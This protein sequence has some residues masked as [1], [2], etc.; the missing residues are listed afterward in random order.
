MPNNLA[1]LDRYF[2]I[3][4]PKDL[5]GKFEIVDSMNKPVNVSKSNLLQQIISL[6]I[7]TGEN[8]AST[9]LPTMKEIVDQVNLFL[10]QKNE[11]DS[12]SIEQFH[13]LIK[14]YS[15]DRVKQSEKYW[16]GDKKQT[17]SWADV[18]KNSNARPKLGVIQTTTPFA[19]LAVRNTNK[20]SLFMNSIPTLEFTRA[21][22]FLDVKFQF[23]RS[24]TENDD[25]LRIPSL[26]K[27]LEGPISPKNAD[28]TMAAGLVET[29]NTPDGE[30]RD[31]YKGGMELFTSP[32]TLV[33]PS[34]AKGSSRYVR[35]LDPFRP[36]MSLTQFEITVVPTVGL[37]TNKTAKL[38]MI[39]HDRS[40]LGEI[41][42]LVRPEIYTNTTLSISYGWKHPDKIDS[43][44][45]FGDLLNRMSV[46]NEK[47]GIVNCSFQFDQV[48]QCHIT[49]QL[50]TKGT[51]DLRVLRL[52]DDQNY[53][54]QS[55][56][57]AQLTSDIA[58]L[59]EDAGLKKP[60][61]LGREVRAYQL[62]DVAEKGQVVYDPKQLQEIREYIRTL[63]SSKANK[64]AMTQLAEKLDSLFAD[65][66][67][68]NEI[69][70]Q[71]VDAAIT[72]KFKELE[73]GE[74]PFL[75]RDENGELVDTIRN[76][77]QEPNS[78]QKKGK[79][80]VS[81]AKVMLTFVGSGFQAISNVDEAQFFFYQFNSKAGKLGN[82][83]IGSFPIEIQYLKTTFEEYAKSKQNPNMTIYEFLDFLQG[84][85]IQDPRAIGY[86]LRQAYTPRTGKKDTD[87]KPGVKLENVL[88]EVVKGGGSFKFP[89][90]EAQIETL[91]GRPVYINEL[92]SE[93]EA[94]DILRIHIYDKAASPYEPM[95]QMLKSQSD[96]QDVIKNQQSSSSESQIAQK[97]ISDAINLAN[98]SG[99][100]IQYDQTTSKY[101]IEGASYQK[102]KDFI[103]Q[104]I[105]TITYGSNN[106]GVINATLQTQ[107][108]QLLSTVQQLREAGRQNNT[109]PNGS[110]FGG[111]P[112]RII[113]AQLDVDTFGC[114]LLN[115][116]QQF[117]FDFQTGT[118]ADNIYLLTNI[119]HTI[120]PGR[121]DSHA[122]F[123]PLDA[124]GVFESVVAKI[125]QLKSYLTNS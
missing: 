32:Q 92:A 57:F 124:Y 27:F 15:E 90:I 123:V 45:A 100:N 11:A 36:F 106:S 55:K 76:F 21:V 77:N 70:K 17:I 3:I 83:N 18:I 66:K 119:T 117:Y 112:L 122:K 105:P 19:S 7:N 46:K 14:I 59:R 49:L 113:P 114:P 6:L 121:F 23:S 13:S 28:A 67:G 1:E 34:S 118:T 120:K 81:L 62:L 108:N 86:G 110:A 63:K 88:E 10:Q 50:A 93:K 91:S 104:V 69:L 29:L 5:L 8:Q 89:V 22:P 12:V 111:I 20:I 4:Q 53:H 85:I 37:F 47:Y 52:A 115:V 79:R 87:I 48:G 94:N 75:Q 58:Q 101:K 109:E 84:A 2:R 41:S 125:D 42:D 35:V 61:S 74:D 25:R 26:L 9:G 78:N 107:Q 73:E 51:Q 71:T 43:E 44:N 40:R 54:D 64:P 56:F 33:N 31:V 72:S 16:L 82:V 97:S 102:I 116:N 68:V 98:Q 38:S 65:K 30:K 80:V 99:L 103:T 24:K 60:E 39:L 95:L 96:L